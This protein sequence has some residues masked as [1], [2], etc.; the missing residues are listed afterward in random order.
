MSGRQKKYDIFISYRRD[1]GELISECLHLTLDKIGYKV[2]RDQQS[3][4]RG[5]FDEALLEAI[6]NSKDFIFILT[7]NSMD[8]CMEDND[9][10]RREIK[11]ALDNHINS[12]PLIF[13]GFEW[14]DLPDDIK[15]FKRLNGVETD[16]HNLTADI[17]IRLLKLLTSLPTDQ[18]KENTILAG[19]MEVPTPKFIG[20]HRELSEIHDAF[21]NGQKVV[22]ISGM[23]GLGKSELAKA[24]A[25]RYKQEYDNVLFVRYEESI[26]HT[27]TD[28]NLFNID[29]IRRAV[30]DSV[31]AESPEFYFSRKLSSMVG[32]T[33]SKTLIILDNYDVDLQD[34]N[35]Y[36]Y[37]FLSTG[38]YRVLVTSRADF[39]E[40]YHTV[41]LVNAGDIMDSRRLFEA[42]YDGKV[43]QNQLTYLD[44][45]LQE[46]GYHT[47][48]IEI[49]AKSMKKSHKS[50]MQMYDLLKNEGVKSLN[51]LIKGPKIHSQSDIAYKYIENLFVT[52]DMTVDEKTI[53]ASLALM[54]KTGVFAS[55][56]MEWAGIDGFDTINSLIERSWIIWDAD[57]DYISVH[58]VI[59]DI[60]KLKLLPDS[61]LCTNLLDT[62][63]E[64]FDNKIQDYIEE[65]DYENAIDLL[66]I[67]NHWVKE[68]L[69]IS[70]P[71][72]E[73]IMFCVASCYYSMCWFSEA[74]PYYKEL[75]NSQIT[76]NKLICDLDHLNNFRLYGYCLS[77]GSH[78]KYTAYEVRRTIL[79]HAMELLSE[80]DPRLLDFQEDVANS[81]NDIGKY[82]QALEIRLNILDAY[83]VDKNISLAKVLYEESGLSNVYMSLK[84]YSEATALRE[85][86]TNKTEKYYPEA[87]VA[88][89]VAKSN[90]AC[91]YLLTNKIYEALAMLKDA[92]ST[93]DRV[94]GCDNFYT[95][96]VRSNLGAARIICKDDD[97]VLDNQVTYDKQASIWGADYD[98]TIGTG[99]NLATAL[100]T[101]NDVKKAHDLE[102][103]LQKQLSRITGSSDE[104]KDLIRNNIEITNGDYQKERQF[105][106]V[107]LM[108]PIRHLF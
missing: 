107:P 2:F 10:V 23:G 61:N 80:D 57:R 92:Y 32:A 36:D 29:G 47:L 75:Y 67:I 70:D 20:R 86:I 74:I 49:I 55:D 30:A 43:S 15:D 46:V 87:Q 94:L 90:L 59:Q 93:L 103:S 68:L 102:L 33:N 21:S 5:Y 17:K 64:L 18:I 42:Y 63:R 82:E 108:L 16:K 104:L 31:N 85:E 53:M 12:I 44:L 3:L 45:M 83:K 77:N 6:R 100:F 65:H 84:R 51:S 69:K 4:G 11:T 24:Y 54:P 22:V 106:T 78:E 26:V 1:G 52:D 13:R 81:A 76:D 105:F 97:A 79:E 41:K 98:V 48:T 60:V 101:F 99:I 25:Y 58:P 62:A 91:C 73:Q 95:L 89:A 9:W 50:A 34:L 14:P 72:R 39:S 38:D 56:F 7:E 40:F 19:K 27:F 96:C 8:R 28:D 66:L 37:D 35:E 88:C 71:L